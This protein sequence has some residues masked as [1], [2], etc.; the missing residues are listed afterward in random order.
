MLDLYTAG[1][2]NGQRATLVVEESGLPYRLHKID[3]AGGGARTAPGL[4]CLACSGSGGL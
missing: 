4:S 2:N 3:I 1:T